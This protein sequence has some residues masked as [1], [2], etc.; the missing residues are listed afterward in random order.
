MAFGFA[1]RNRFG[2]AIDD[3]LCVE[4]GLERGFEAVEYYRAIRKLGPVKPI[5]IS[6]QVR[7][8]SGRVEAF[9]SIGCLPAVSY[10]RSSSPSLGA[11]IV[12]PSGELASRNI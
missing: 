1:P 12:A 4:F 11:I 10:V 8:S 3:F 2:W 6:K 7:V 5:S 9:E